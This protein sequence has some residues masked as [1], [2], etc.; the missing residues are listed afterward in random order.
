M[1]I[2][3]VLFDF[4]GTLVDSFA[5]IAASTNHVRASYGLPPMAEAEVRRTTSWPTSC[6]SR[7]WT[8]PWPGIANTTPASWC[9]R[10]G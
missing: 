6:P 7:R 3:A 10:R 9:R 5:A 1:S 8:R 2:N 4:D